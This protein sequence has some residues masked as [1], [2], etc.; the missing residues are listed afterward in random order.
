MINPRR[1]RFESI[2]NRIKE[3]QN[4]LLIGIDVAKDK[5]NASFMVPAAVC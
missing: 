3:A 2:K 1:E 5:H 4:Y